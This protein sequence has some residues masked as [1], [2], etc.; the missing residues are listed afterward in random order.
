MNQHNVSV[1]QCQMQYGKIPVT[2]ALL[3]VKGPSSP[4]V[5]A[6]LE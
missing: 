3:D 4:L 1:L 2:L 5:G 6:K